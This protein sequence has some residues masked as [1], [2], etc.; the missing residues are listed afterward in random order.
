M[1][2]T[3]Q[4]IQ[5]FFTSI[6]PGAALPALLGAGL[7]TIVIISLISFLFISR[8]IKETRES[9]RKTT[10]K[11]FERLFNAALSRIENNESTPTEFGIGQLITS[12]RFSSSFTST[13]KQHV[14]EEIINYFRSVK[15]IY[16]NVLHCIYDQMRLEELS[17]N[18]LNSS[19]PQ[20]IIHGLRELSEMGMY[21]SWNDIIRLMKKNHPDI[22]QELLYALAKQSPDKL[23]FYIEYR[24]HYL[25]SWD[26]INIHAAF[27]QLSSE[28]LPEFSKWF[29]SKNQNIA[30]FAIKMTGAFQQQS[31][32]EK[33]PELLKK[34]RNDKKILA[35]I[36]VIERFEG[37]ELANDLMHVIFKWIKHEDIV[38]KTLSV[39]DN[40]T[41]PDTLLTIVRKIAAYPSYRI[42]NRLIHFV[43]KHEGIHDNVSGD[44]SEIFNLVKTA[45]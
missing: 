23:L 28:K 24:Y 29:F 14:L 36:E 21:I 34:T 6:E 42:H 32:Y 43:E 5:N 1:S 31:S 33:I 30:L 40:L 16:K 25:T 18:K 3:L 26:E 15:G 7:F 38:Y 41:D 11:K 27:K 22:K 10:V 9:F 12:L 35:A 8:I 39:L 20:H 37:G 13:Q 2:A 19:D 17:I 44:K 45:S 4:H